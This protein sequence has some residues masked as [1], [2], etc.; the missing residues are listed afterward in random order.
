MPIPAVLGAALI[1]AG[2]SATSNLLNLG[3]TGRQ[4]RLSREFSREMYEKQRADA[5]E[6]WGM[7]NAYNAPQAQMER[8]QAAGLNPNLIYG[9]AG[10][11]SA[12]NIPIPDVQPAQF[13]VPEIKDLE[14]MANLLGM[15]DLRIKNAQ[16]NNLNQQT[17]VIRQDAVLRAI[18]A[19]QAGFNLDYATEFRGLNADAL[20]ESVRQ[21][22]IFTDLAVNKDAREAIQLSSNV[23]EAAQRILNL[24]ETRKGFVLQR[25]QTEAETRRIYQNIKLMQKDGTLKDFEILLNKSNVTKSD[26]LWMRL[27]L[28]FLQGRSNEPKPGPFKK[29]QDVPLTP[30]R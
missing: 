21:R 1:G 5:L 29:Y 14:L 19:K 20:Y 3:M 26:P 24:I 25:G 4:N 6:F 7:Q 22:R 28:D 17:E 30:K 11:N 10:D 15:A 18:Q 13:R 27:I 8:F 23:S 12:G 16:A 9:Q 2:S